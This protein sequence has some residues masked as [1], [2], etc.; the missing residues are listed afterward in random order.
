MKIEKNLLNNKSLNTPDDIAGI[1]LDYLEIYDVDKRE[2]MEH[3]LFF[4]LYDWYKVIRDPVY[5]EFNIDQ[6]KLY[7]LMSAISDKMESDKN[8]E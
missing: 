5:Y 3:R 4:L 2:R 7:E 1:F 8:E 6:V